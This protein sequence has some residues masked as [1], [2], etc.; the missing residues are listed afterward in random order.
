MGSQSLPP[1]GL[2][3]C[4]DLVW[5]ILFFLDNATAKSQPVRICIVSCN[6]SM[7]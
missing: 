5:G 6:I 4:L 7:F 3:F 2:L 1:D